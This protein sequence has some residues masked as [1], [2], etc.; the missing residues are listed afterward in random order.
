MIAEIEFCFWVQDKIFYKKVVK[1]L[2]KQ[3]NECLTLEGNYF[4]D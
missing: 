2:R 3:Y 1:M 4:D